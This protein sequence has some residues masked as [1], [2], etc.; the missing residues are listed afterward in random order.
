MPPP[1]LSA[2]MHACLHACLNACLDACLR[3]R[4][5][6]PPSCYAVSLLCHAMLRYAVPRQEAARVWRSAHWQH[7]PR[8]LPGSHPQLGPTAG[9]QALRPPMWV[10]LQVGR[11]CILPCG[12]TVRRW[13]LHTPILLPNCSR[14]RYEPYPTAI[15]VNNTHSS[16][17]QQCL[18]LSPSSPATGFCT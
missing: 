14:M 12:S 15:C 8:Q 5:D 6:D 17:P 13:A 3:V 10:P 1:C 11:L 2:C 7:S 9:R 4:L 18:I 16:A